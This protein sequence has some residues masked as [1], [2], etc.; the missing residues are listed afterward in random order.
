MIVYQ[1]TGQSTCNSRKAYN[2]DMII[3]NKHTPILNVDDVVQ[4]EQRVSA[5]GIGLDILMRNAGSALAETIRH[6]APTPCPVCILAG[7]GN[8]GGDGWAAAEFLALTGYD[9]TVI[10]MAKPDQITAQPAH[11]VAHRTAIHSPKSHL[12]IVV[13]PDTDTCR[14]Y[15]EQTPFIIDALLGTG[16][17][18]SVI[19]APFD[20][21]VR[22]ANA[23]H[24][25]KLTHVIA[26]DVPSGLSAQTGTTSDPSVHAD[27]TVTMMV[28]KP[29]LL[30]E[31]GQKVC[32][33][34]TVASICPLDSFQSFI[35]EHDLQN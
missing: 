17:R 12:H 1:A 20:E 24:D 7:N 13:N 14:K 31:T 26:A 11:D 5:K 27:T 4:L 25:H 33:A 35:D 6:Q 23:A 3:S 34:L 9:T 22:L 16:F 28:R 18:G 15:I 10:C 32:G 8:N 30:T 19:R 21:W 29:G 2:T